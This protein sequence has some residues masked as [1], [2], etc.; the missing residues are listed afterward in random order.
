ML[1]S[2]IVGIPD[3]CKP[4]FLQVQISTYTRYVFL[5]VAV[6]IGFIVL[7][8]YFYTKAGGPRVFFY[9]TYKGK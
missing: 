5:Y 7:Y 3:N 4:D 9:E 1:T 2:I 8:T 6:S